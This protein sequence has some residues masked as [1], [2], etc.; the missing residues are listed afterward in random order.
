MSPAI[1]KKQRRAM[2]IAEHSSE[3]LYKRNKGMA[4]MSKSQLHDFASTKEKGLANK[5]KK[6]T[7]GSPSMT[8]CELSQGYRSLEKCPQGGK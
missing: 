2:A 8:G 3:E 7:K 1:S 5:V 4:K 6:S